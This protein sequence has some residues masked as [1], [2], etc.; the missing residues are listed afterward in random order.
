VLSTQ[1][2][3]GRISWFATWGGG[4]NCDAS[5]GHFGS[6]CTTCGLLLQK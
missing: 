6:L 1:Y 4:T 3:A 5:L 2:D